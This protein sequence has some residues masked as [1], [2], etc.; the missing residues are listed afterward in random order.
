[1]TDNLTKCRR[2]LL[3]DCRDTDT[4]CPPLTTWRE[5]ATHLVSQV[6]TDDGEACLK[7]LRKC[8]QYKEL[9]TEVGGDRQHALFEQE[10]NGD[11]LQHFDNV[12]E[13]NARLNSF[14][15]EDLDENYEEL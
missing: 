9:H 8:E 15:N 13:L 12:T 14:F 6:G 1:M 11:A 5:I 7:L 2:E 10:K 4:P 3:E